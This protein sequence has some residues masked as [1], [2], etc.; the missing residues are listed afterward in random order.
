MLE[1]IFL[2]LKN[3]KKAKYLKANLDSLYEEALKL[4]SPC[5]L[6]ERRCKAKRPEETGVCGVGHSYVSSM[7]EHWGEE[8]E[9]VPS[10]TIFFSGC[11][12]FCVYCQNWDIARF[13]KAGRLA[14]PKAIASWIETA[15]IRNINFVGG[16]PTLH[17]PTIIEI[18]KHCKR[19]LPVIW[20][21]NMYMSKGC[22]SILNEFVDVFL[23]DFRYGNDECALRLSNVPNYT[24]IVKRNFKLVKGDILVRVLLLP[25][26]IECCAKPILRWISR[27]LKDAYVNVLT[28]YRP[29]YRAK[30]FPEINRVLTDEE[31]AEITEFIRERNFKLQI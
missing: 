15:N 29:E 16:E 9:L 30:E 26:H 25:N 7:F 24:K 6:C 27:N 17:L 31:I 4:F 2:V 3:K 19:N 21:S 28:Q 22:I 12:F 23:G 14:D 11:N 20:N 18:L 13:P 8:P 5:V 1:T 10:G